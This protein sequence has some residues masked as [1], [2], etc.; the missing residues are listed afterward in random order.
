[1]DKEIEN[2]LELLTQVLEVHSKVLTE[3]ISRQE[4]Y[5]I[6]LYALIASHPS[7]TAFAQELRRWSE[8]AGLSLS[9]EEQIPERDSAIDTLLS[10]LESAC[11]VPL[12]LRAPK[13]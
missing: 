13:A 10:A 1:M 9:S 8:R 6:V 3:A 2:R 7:P 5:S 11:P 12:N 4:I